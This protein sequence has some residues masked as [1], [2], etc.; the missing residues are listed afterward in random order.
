MPDHDELNR[1]RQQR[2]ARRKEQLAEQRRL[3]RNL[4]IAAVVLVICAAA[5][6]F[7]G[8][9]GGEASPETMEDMPTESTE[10]PVT[11]SPTTEPKET[12]KSKRDP[13]TVVH[14]RAAG[15]L[16]ITDEVLLAGAGTG[17][18]DFTRC[19]QNVAG[20]LSGADMTL[21]NFE[22]ILS[23]E[24][25]G[26]ART[27][28][29]VQIA[30]ALQAAG[31][32]M[33]QTANSNS[34]RNGLIG[35]TSTL[36]NFRNA[37]IEPVGTF[38]SP[39]EFKKSKGYTIC[40]IQGIKVAVVA[41]TKG[42]G[43]MGLPEGSEDCVN[44]L[45]TDYASTYQEI[46]KDGIKKILKAVASEKPDITIALL[47]WGSEYND[48]ISDSQKS[49]ASL[50]KS[51]GVDIIIGT[52]P[53][54]VQQI[55]YNESEDTLVAYSLGDFFGSATEAGSNYSIIL[56]VEITKDSDAGTTEITGY[57]VIPIYTL[58]ESETCDNQ[59]RV[60][61]IE[62]AMKA[63]EEDFVDKV[64]PE[65]YASMAAALERIEERVKPPKDDK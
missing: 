31:V 6:L 37:G 60:V 9:S 29:P 22:G 2:E 15:D 18:Y 1:R 62:D 14:I 43:S 56:D 19:F 34:V 36:N 30:Q 24:P 57:S 28:A 33:V 42:V 64:T 50:M 13:V 46:D 44:L 47:H 21:L 5:I 53:H 45:Y 16:N 61:V 65:A 58:K 40:E 63:Y 17:D 54:R 55:E 51:Q 38:S 12:E 48:N 20:A 26:A 11:Q 32:D 39:E 10:A 8:R 35:L 49:I 27:S 59:R 3:K 25:Y 7:L 23:G 41:F 4:I 52:H